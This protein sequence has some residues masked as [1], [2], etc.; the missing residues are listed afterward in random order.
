[1]KLTAITA[2]F[3]LFLAG[4]SA[5]EKPLDIEVVSSTPCPEDQQTKKGMPPL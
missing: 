1:M 5:L 4:V 2:A 3:G